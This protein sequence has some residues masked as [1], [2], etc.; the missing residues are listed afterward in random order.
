MRNLFQ[1]TLF[2]LVVFNILIS[3]QSN[4][5]SDI[6][7]KQVLMDSI[8]AKEADLHSDIEVDEEKAREMTALYLNYSNRYK[9]DSLSSEYLFRAAEI[10]M[11]T[12]KPIDACSYLYRIERQYEDFDKMPAVIYLLGFVNQNMIGDKKNAEAYYQKFLDRYP[13]HS[14]AEEV[15]IILNSIYID[16]LELVREFE[17]QNAENE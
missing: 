10:A 11:N 14:R 13:N 16:D 2:I 6:D 17:T 4:N 9:K 12:D 1:F 3:C 15:A 5:T 8:Q 7:S